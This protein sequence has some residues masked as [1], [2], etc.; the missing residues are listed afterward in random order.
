[1]FHP[2]ETETDRSARDKLRKQL[3]Y[4]P[5]VI[6]CIST[7]RLTRD[8]GPH[9]LAHAVVRLIAEGEPYRGLFVGDGASEYVDRLRRAP[10]AVFCRLFT[11]R[12]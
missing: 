9:V 3:G 11:A 4:G 6:V 10:G 1:L 12:S 2:V 5:E 7:G 8:K